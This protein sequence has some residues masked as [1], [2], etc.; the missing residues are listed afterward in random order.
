MKQDY[1]FNRKN[2][3][4]LKEKKESSKYESYKYSLN[5]SGFMILLTFT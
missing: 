1:K 3:R 4:P 2:F 5:D